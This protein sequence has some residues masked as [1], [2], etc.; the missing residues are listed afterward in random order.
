MA[1]NTPTT[2]VT[3]TEL[4]APDLNAQVRDNFKAIGDPWT[5][6]AGSIVTTNIT[7]GNGTL[8]AVYM[9]AGKFV[10]FRVKFT[11]GSTSAITGSPTFTLPVTAVG[12]RVVGGLLLMFDSSAASGSAYKLGGAFNSTTT[13]LLIRDDASAVISSTSPFT[14][15]TGDELVIT[16]DYEAA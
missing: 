16:G 1:W 12:T 7:V 8:T 13:N 6:Y 3:A 9:Q 15:A 14:W 5:S 10:Q 2:W 11:L 4:D